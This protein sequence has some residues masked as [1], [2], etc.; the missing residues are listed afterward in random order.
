MKYCLY[1]LSFNAVM[2]PKSMDK[3]GNTKPKLGFPSNCKRYWQ[4]ILDITAACSCYS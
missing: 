3:E 4:Q 2:F 1:C